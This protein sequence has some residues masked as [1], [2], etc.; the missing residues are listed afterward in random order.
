MF[1]M[2]RIVLLGDKAKME[3]RFGPFRDSVSFSAKIGA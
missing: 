1:L 3:A 2:H